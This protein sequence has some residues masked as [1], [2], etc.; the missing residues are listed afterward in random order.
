MNSL[1][2]ELEGLKKENTDL[3]KIKKLKQ[4]IKVW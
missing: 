4:Q 2:K 1:E 3:T